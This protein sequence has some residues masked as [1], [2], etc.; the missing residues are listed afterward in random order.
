MALSTRHPSAASGQV[1]TPYI[2]F[3][4]S[5][6]VVY[7]ILVSCLLAV[8]EF[9][10]ACG[11]VCV[12]A[13]CSLHNT[14]R[15]LL[16]YTLAS[17]LTIPIFLAIWIRCWRFKRLAYAALGAFLVSNATLACGAGTLVVTVEHLLCPSDPAVEFAGVLLIFIAQ[18]WSGMLVEIVFRKRAA[19][20]SKK[21]VGFTNTESSA[22]AERF[23]EGSSGEEEL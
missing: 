19:F 4:T 10:S 7:F 3:L 11:S 14:T 22:V 20:N 23:V 5:G 8:V 21:Y 12:E 18:T 13:A 9:R 6:V 17:N 1:S 16:I 2:I 15:F